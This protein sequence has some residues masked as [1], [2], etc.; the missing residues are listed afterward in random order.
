VT[1]ENYELAD[2]LQMQHIS[3]NAFNDLAIKADER[4]NRL[5]CVKG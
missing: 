1:T 3:R 5:K 4:F 2:R